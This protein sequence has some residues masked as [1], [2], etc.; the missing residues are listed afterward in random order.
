MSTAAGRW[1]DGFGEGSTHA[2]AEHWDLVVAPLMSGHVERERE[3][4]SSGGKRR[5]KGGTCSNLL[6]DSAW[7]L[8]SPNSMLVPS[9]AQSSLIRTL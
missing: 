2:M 7:P 4:M 9:R 8:C 1:N 3:I 5:A 6:V